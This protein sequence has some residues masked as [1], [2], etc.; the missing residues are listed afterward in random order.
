MSVKKYLFILIALFLLAAC[1]EETVNIE[2]EVLKYEELQSKII[3]S[4]QELESV[5][6]ELSEIKDALIDNNDKYE[7]LEELASNRD[8][9]TQ[10]L[11][12]AELKLESLQAEISK[13]EEELVTVAK[14]PETTEEVVEEVTT[15]NA[16]ETLSQKNE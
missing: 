12:D 7:G 10:E 3:T 4:E 15:E 2:G 1:S 11:E 14:K 8:R 16:D 13:L 5:T 6:N 9:I